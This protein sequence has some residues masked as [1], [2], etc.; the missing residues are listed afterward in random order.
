MN[1]LVLL[2]VTL[3]GELSCTDV[4]LERPFISVH[5]SSVNDKIRL[6]L[7]RFATVWE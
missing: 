2:K 4:A 7:I 3:G 5:T 6:A 1:P